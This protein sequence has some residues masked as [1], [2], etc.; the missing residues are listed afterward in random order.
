[1][2]VLYIAEYAELARAE[3]G[4]GQI[5]QAPP[6]AEQ[7]VAIGAGSVSSLA[8]NAST[9]FIRLSTDAI[10]SISIDFNPTATT[11]KGRMPADAVEYFGVKPGMKTAVISNI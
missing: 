3:P 5:A 2:A 4:M 10:C 7:T 11:V 6:V 8:F 9:R 1:M